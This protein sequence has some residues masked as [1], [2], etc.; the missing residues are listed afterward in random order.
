M[1]KKKR[2]PDTEL[3]VMQAI[4]EHGDEI[5]R[6]DIEGVLA[7]HAWS[8]NT[9]NTYLTRLCEK[10]Y[11]ESRREGRSNLYRPLVQKQEYLEFE[12]RST[13][14]RLYDGKLKNFIA[15]LTAERP[16]AQEE[17]DELR[18]HLDQMSQK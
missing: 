9:I 13:L 3:S 18:R 2:L 5:S 8:A 14:S 12:S 4:W 11:L 16:L 1:E 17:I 6:S 7:E 10:G 15:A